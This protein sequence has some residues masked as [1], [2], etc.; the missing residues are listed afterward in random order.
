MRVRDCVGGHFVLQRPLL[1]GAVN[2]AQ[3]VNASRGRLPLWRGQA[4]ARIDRCLDAGLILRLPVEG[5]HLL[6][7]G[8]GEL[9]GLGLRALGRRLRALCLLREGLLIVAQ[10]ADFASQ[11]EQLLIV[12]AQPVQL[13]SRRVRLLSAESAPHSTPRHRR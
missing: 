3:V 2:L 6:F 12:F 8:F 1:F 9:D 5:G 10:L 7:G 4:A 13:R 11:T